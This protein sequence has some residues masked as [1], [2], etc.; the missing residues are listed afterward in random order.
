MIVTKRTLEAMGLCGNHWAQAAHRFVGKDREVTFGNL[1]LSLEKGMDLC[2]FMDYWLRLNA[3]GGRPIKDTG[4]IDPELLWIYEGYLEALGEVR[5]E[6][7]TPRYG[8]LR[9]RYTEQA[10]RAEIYLNA[11]ESLWHQRRWTI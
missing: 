3:G 5:R 7:R 11:F 6:E 1:V 10:A 9:N 2:F 4:P 8:F